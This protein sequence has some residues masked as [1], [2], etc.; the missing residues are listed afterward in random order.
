MATESQTRVRERAS[1]Q[2]DEVKRRA[3][4][5][6]EQQAETLKTEMG[7][8]VF[9][10][11]EENFPEAARERRRQGMAAAFG[12]GVLAGVLVRSLPPKR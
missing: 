6:A 1:Q 5:G 11:A 7:R 10:F 3:R 8:A 12:V 4:Q 9:D 2:A